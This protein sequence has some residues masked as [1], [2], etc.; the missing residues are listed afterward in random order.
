MSLDDESFLIPNFSENSWVRQMKKWKC[1]YDD[2]DDIKM[3]TGN[4]IPMDIHL[5][6]LWDLSPWHWLVQIS[7]FMKSAY[8]R[9][10]VNKWVQFP[11]VLYCEYGGIGRRTRLKIC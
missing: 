9:N 7:H 11:P 4:I 2:D 10:H 1:H 6:I 5:L 8:N 3:Y